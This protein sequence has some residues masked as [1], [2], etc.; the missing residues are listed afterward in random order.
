MVAVALAVTVAVAV[1]VVI[2]VA[3]TIT[4]STADSTA[5]SIVASIAGSTAGSTAGS[6]A[7]P[8][9]LACPIVLLRI[10]TFFATSAF[11]ASPVDPTCDSVVLVVVSNN[12]ASTSLITTLVASSS[13]GAD[14]LLKDLSGDCS[15]CAVAF[16]REN[17]LMML[18]LS[19]RIVGVAFLVGD[20]AFFF[21]FFF[22]FFLSFRSS[23]LGLPIDRA[24]ALLLM[25]HRSTID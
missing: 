10:G 13:V 23:Y 25:H 19:C 8:D 20:A 22:F 15:N 2:A 7:G 11:L 12:I 18:G 5:D 16:S 1:A 24:F 21:F 3:V 9:P 17:S 14:T 4:G 6:I